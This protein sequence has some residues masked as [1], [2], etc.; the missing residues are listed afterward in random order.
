MSISFCLCSLCCLFAWPCWWLRD[1][2]YITLALVGGLKMKIFAYF[3]YINYDYE[4]GGGGPKGLKMC[5]RNKWM[6]PRTMHSRRRSRGINCNSLWS[7]EAVLRLLRGCNQRFWGQRW[8]CC[9]KSFREIIV[10]QIAATSA[11]GPFIYYV[12]TWK[13]EVGQIIVLFAYFQGIK[14][15]Y[16]VGGWVKNVPKL[17]YVIYE[18]Y[19]AWARACSCMPKHLSWGLEAVF[20]PHFFSFARLFTSLPAFLFRPYS[21]ARKKE[22]KNG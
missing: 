18:W 19:L 21:S 16:I 20:W 4:R 7:F 13:G 8:G 9:W 5:L 11:R 6:V 17:A 2:S 1:H 10:V 3:Q 12:S 14:Y 22:K 15:D